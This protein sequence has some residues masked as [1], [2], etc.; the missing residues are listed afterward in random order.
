MLSH[1]IP[2]SFRK[3]LQI[4]VISVLLTPIWSYSAQAF[5]CPS[6]ARVKDEAF[7]RFFRMYR[8]G[9]DPLDA[10]IT[11]RLKV[12]VGQKVR[13]IAVVIGNSVYKNLEGADLPPAKIDFDN[14][15]RFFSTTQQFDEVIGL[16]NDDA[17]RSSIGYFLDEYLVDRSASFPNSARLVVAYSG[18]G[19]PARG[20]FPAALVLAGAQSTSEAANLYPLSS[21]K[22]SLQNLSGA[23]FHVLALINA[24]YGGAVFD[25]ALGGGNQS[26]STEPGAHA[27]TAGPN[28][29]LVYSLGETGQGSIFFDSLIKGIE[30]GEADIFFVNEVD[31]QSR[32]SRHKGDIVR[33]GGLVSYLTNEI[34]NINTIR[35]RADPGAVPYNGPWSGSI[36]PIK[37]TARGAFFFLSPKAATQVSFGLP[38]TI[39]PSGSIRLPS[40]RSIDGLGVQPYPT[41]SS[42]PGSAS[43]SVNSRITRD[44]NSSLR[45]VILPNDS[46]TGIS[47]FNNEPGAARTSR[48]GSRVSPPIS[49]GSPSI[50]PAS[51]PTSLSG[52]KVFNPP[53]EYLIRGID[54]STFEAA[55]DWK[56]VRRVGI[57]F[58][59]INSV[60][61]A[62]F[63]SKFAAHWA[64]T[65]D[66]GIP[67]GANLVYD[68]CKPA[69]LQ[70][71]LFL[72][73]VPIDNS[74]L[75]AALN[76]ELTSD[77]NQETCRTAKSR[78]DRSNDIYNILDSLAKRYSKVPLVY[79]NGQLLSGIL[80]ERFDRFMI[81]IASKS[82]DDVASLK[83]SGNNTW[84]LWQFTTT[85]GVDAVGANVKLSAF[86]GTRAE[87][88]EFVVGKS[89]VALSSGKNQ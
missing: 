21:L 56:T 42:A 87:F 77:V 13:S 82:P 44:I 69:A 54:V 75:P 31:S 14:L 10:R 29:E 45:N 49:D 86:F 35:L 25:V 24:C 39:Q 22:S 4:A 2:V 41:Q 40:D 83:L 62:G 12:G 32:L 34:E 27:L 15:V 47:R 76:L 50:A 85:A 67:R 6:G 63:N 33:L 1:L 84:T 26:I 48:V 8:T 43:P 16:E 53:D 71:E 52:R 28:D 17:T 36:E 38:A 89:N 55:I 59:Y 73:N 30:R 23:Y 74:A 3:F 79:G 51:A 19:I 68:W 11:K 70:L 9:D 20:P 65:K 7:C 64:Q 72:S 66:A 81:W 60:G 78:T 61:P 57:D 46:G 58:A 18:H 88:G 5:V 80:D 37:S